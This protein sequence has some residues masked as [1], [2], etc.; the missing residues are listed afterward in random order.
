MQSFKYIAKTKEGKAQKGTLE[1][2]SRQDALLILREK[3]LVVLSL[4][5]TTS[6]QIF[7]GGNK[8]SPKERLLITEQL[9]IMVKAGLPLIE[10]LQV[11]SEEA[12]NKR[13]GKILTRVGSD[14][15]GGNSLSE[16][17]AKSGAFPSY[18]LAVIRSG[19]KSGKLEEIM[20]RLAQNLKRD[21]QLRARLKSA[22]ILPSVILIAMFAVIALILVYV[23]PQLMGIFVESDVELPMSTRFLLAAS[24]A[25]TS[26]WYIFLALIILCFSAFKAIAMTPKGRYVLDR[27]KLKLPIFGMLIE[28]V[29]VARFAGTMSTL[30]SAGMPMLEIIATT[31]DVIDNSVFHRGLNASKKDVEGG[32]ALS[33]SIRKRGYFP[34]LVPHMIAIGEKSG[35]LEYVFNEIAKLYDDEAQNITKN[36]MT[37]MEP[38]ITVVLGLGVAFIMSSVISPIYKL[39]NTID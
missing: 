4:Q 18:Y 34:A 35:N 23:L 28:K 38:I 1:A 21:A 19:E 39:M 36:M 24:G 22:L 2:T 30:I 16:A 6:W 14:I 10:A 29:A 26:Y 25:M 20:M 9:S 33:A 11:L 32:E 37:L 27:V 12:T 15:K 8:I 3:K 7:S 31:S 5:T 13:V 17:L